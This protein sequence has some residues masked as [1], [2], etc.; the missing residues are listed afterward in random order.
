MESK[1]CRIYTKLFLK[2]ILI[3]VSDDYFTHINQFSNLDFLFFGH[4]DDCRATSESERINL[5]VLQYQTSHLGNIGS[6]ASSLLSLD[7]VGCF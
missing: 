3:A 4:K 6:D 2:L 7:V 1:E 5:D